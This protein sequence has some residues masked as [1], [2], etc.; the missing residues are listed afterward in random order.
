MLEAFKITSNIPETASFTEI[1]IVTIS[2][3]LASLCGEGYAIVGIF[4]FGAVLSI[5][6]NPSD[7]SLISVSFSIIYILYLLPSALVLVS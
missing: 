3:F 1:V 5:V 4:T 2:L 6:K 7:K